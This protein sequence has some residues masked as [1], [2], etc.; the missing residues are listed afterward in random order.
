[1]L[2][3][4]LDGYTPPGAII[5]SNGETDG[6]GTSVP[7]YGAPPDLTRPPRSTPLPPQPPV[8]TVPLPHRSP[9]AAPPPPL[10]PVTDS[11]EVAT[12]ASRP[13]SW[14]GLDMSNPANWG[15]SQWEAAFKENPEKYMRLFLHMS[16]DGTLSPSAQQHQKELELTA[17]DAVQSENRMFSGLKALL[18]AEHETLKSLVSFRV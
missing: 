15:P 1:M 9:A 11:I 10:P 5:L 16:M 3:S 6:T 14:A 12:Q 2:P 4:R 13:A 17:T 18:D 8:V 7:T